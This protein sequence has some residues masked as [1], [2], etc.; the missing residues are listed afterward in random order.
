MILLCLGYLLI[1]AVIERTLHISRIQKTLDGIVSS[2]AFGHQYLDNAEVVASQLEQT[3]RRANESI[4]VLGA[5][6]RIARYL[7]SLEEAVSYRGVIY[8]RLINSDHIDHELHEHL[9]KVLHN[10][11][12]QI[13]WTPREKYGNWV[14]TENE[15]LFV[16]PSPCAEKY[17]GLWLPGQANSR[18]FTQ[19]FLEL[20]FKSLPVRTEKAVE[21]LCIQCSP[22]SARN[23]PKIRSVLEEELRASIGEDTGVRQEWL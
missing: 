3:T 12:V 20:F 21:A 11:N 17:S 2:Y 1:S 10:P 19:Y 15:V 13:A 18:R 6:S 4:M 16:I 23:L 5:K 8:Y 22:T 7:H 9:G 14:V